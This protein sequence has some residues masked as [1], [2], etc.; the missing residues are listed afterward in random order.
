MPKAICKEISHKIGDSNKVSEFIFDSWDFNSQSGILT[1]KYLWD[2][3]LSFVEKIE[4]G[5]SQNP[6]LVNW[7]ALE[8]IACFLHI[9]CGVSY[10]K[11]ALPPV[12]L[13]KTPL[14]PIAREFFRNLYFQGLAEFAYRNHCDLT[15]RITFY[16]PTRKAK[17]IHTKLLNRALIPIGGGRDSLT[18][19]KIMQEAGREFSLFSVNPSRVILKFA[20]IARVP[21]VKVYRTLSPNLFSLNEVGY[22]N[23]HIPITGIISLIACFTAIWHGFQDIVMSNERSANEGNLKAFGIDVNHQYSKSL[24]FENRLRKL[25]NE[26]GACGINY[27]SLLRPLSELSIARLFSSQ[28]EYDDVFTSC[29]RVFKIRN[30]QTDRLWC[31]E[32]PKCHFAFLSLATSFEKKRLINIFGSNLLDNP[33]NIPSY[34]EL[35]GI[36]GHKPWECVGEIEESAAAIG[37]LAESSVW[38]SDVVVA[39]LWERLQDK[40]KRIEQAKV[41]SFFHSDDHNVS[42]ELLT[43]LF[44]LI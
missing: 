29:N 12:L 6:D 7:K 31:G 30:P 20:K 17:A 41:E 21:L 11:A 19:V 39:H 9:A 26:D 38:K 18:S 33:A 15:D 2:N 3:G 14:S 32:C 42:K 34:S 10:Y 44:N 1:L 13:V 28:R 23:G 25:L 16:S 40:Q 35:V 37:I 4:F 5:K 24:D 36:S 27:F 43:Y 22:L 8:R